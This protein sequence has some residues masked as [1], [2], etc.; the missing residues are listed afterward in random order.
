MEDLIKGT[1]NRSSAP[2]KLRITDIR[3]TDVVVVDLY[4]KIFQGT[5]VGGN[6]STE[7]QHLNWDEEME[8][9]RKRA[10]E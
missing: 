6:L 5:Y 9:A 8:E 10:E 2:S 4:D 7:F 1:F 3:F